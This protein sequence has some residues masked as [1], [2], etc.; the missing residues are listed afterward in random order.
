MGRDVA[1]GRA[2]AFGPASPSLAEFP[3][4]SPMF[5]LASDLMALGA[6]EADEIAARFPKVQRRVGGYNIDAFLPGRNESF[7]KFRSALREPFEKRPVEADEAVPRV[8]ILEREAEPEGK[9]ACVGHG[10]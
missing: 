2:A 6:R 9:V 3:P 8:K 4:S 7:V 10:T 1:D 5:S